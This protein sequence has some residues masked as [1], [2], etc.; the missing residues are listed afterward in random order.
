MCIP[1]SSTLQTSLSASTLLC[2]TTPT[3]RGDLALYL[4]LHKFWTG[5]LVRELDGLDLVSIVCE[6]MYHLKEKLAL[7]FLSPTLSSTY[8]LHIVLPVCPCTTQKMLVHCLPQW[9]DNLNYQVFLAIARMGLNACNQHK[10]LRSYYIF[11]SHLG[12]AISFDNKL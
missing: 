5:E 4:L 3:G 11:N 9:H 10:Q 6:E 1:A 8:M 2:V 7:V 12:F